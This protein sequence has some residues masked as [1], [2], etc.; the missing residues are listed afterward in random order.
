MKILSAIYSHP[1]FYPPLL[2]AVDE[3][4]GEADEVI[5]LC[6]NVRETEYKYPP[7]V[8]VKALGQFVPIRQVEKSALYLKIFWF[9][10]FFGSA[11]ILGFKNNSAG[12]VYI[13]ND[14][15]GAAIGITLKRLGFKGKV[16]YYCHD[17]LDISVQSWYS[18]MRLAKKIELSQNG[19]IDLLVI[20]NLE[21]AR[22]LNQSFKKPAEFN[23]VPN[24]PS[25]TQYSGYSQADLNR[26][27]MTHLGTRIKEGDRLVVRSGGL[28]LIGETLEAAALLPETIKF[29][30]LTNL[31][32]PEIRQKLDTQLDE[33]NLKDRFFFFENLNNDQFYQLTAACDAGLALYDNK[34]IN[35]RNMATAGNKLYLYVKYG[36][37]VVSSN[38]PDFVEI[39]SRHPVGLAVNPDS[40]AEI[41]NG[42]SA[43][44][45]E[46]SYRNA[47]RKMFEK[48]WNFTTGFS[49][50]RARILALGNSAETEKG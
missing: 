27:K 11:V 38:Q 25:K 49:E 23:V 15:M 50:A 46:S 19:E 7:N 35:N 33:L 32:S 47:A 45:S 31:I 39:L 34:N 9:L 1:E 43:V 2:N 30:V 26:I 40:P 21:R 48:E 8:R 37:P 16:V 42:I 3:L 14:V 36:L 5:V 22:I 29:L 18:V 6:R 41:A 20:P 44:L 28:I 12:T 24:Y 4:A 10:R 17:L 13:G